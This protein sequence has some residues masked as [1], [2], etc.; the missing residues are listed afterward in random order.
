VLPKVCLEQVSRFPPNHVCF[1]TSLGEHSYTQSNHCGQDTIH[2]HLLIDSD[3]D[4]TLLDGLRVRLLQKTTSYWGGHDI[5]RLAA[6]AGAGAQQTNVIVRIPDWA[7]PEEGHVCHVMLRNQ[8]FANS[9]ITRLK[10]WAI[11][12]PG[13]RGEC[14]ISALPPTFRR[15]R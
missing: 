2:V 4:F 6:R 15:T 13:H 10:R 11:H 8:P 7:R 9:Y 12:I 1:I 5:L 14:S 3:S